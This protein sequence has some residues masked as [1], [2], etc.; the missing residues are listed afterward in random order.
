MHRVMVRTLRGLEAVARTEVVQ[1]LGD[2]PVALEHRSLRF[3]LPRLDRRLLSLGTV[4]DAFLVLGEVDGIGHRRSALEALAALGRTIDGPA[5]VRTLEAVRPVAGAAAASGAISFDATA[6]FIGRR[7]FSRFEI[8]DRVGAAI[9]AATGWTYRPHGLLATSL[10]FRVHVLRAAATLAV[11]LAERPLHRR[12]YRTRS[13]PGALHPPLARALCLLVE[14]TPGCVL[15]D[16]TCG[17]GTIPIEAALLEPDAEVAGF[18]LEPSAIAAARC[19][20]SRAGTAV[21]LGVADATRLPLDD[22]TVDRLVVNPPWDAMVAAAGGL[23][24][25]R[26]ALWTEAARVLAP[27]G[28]LVALLPAGSSPVV[29]GV[30]SEVVASVRVHGAEA[31]VVRARC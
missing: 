16:P 12:A 1:L 10:S 24:R 14:P 18:D 5:I 3:A 13:R 15:V 30:D 22:D 11:R 7:N 4:D 28:S 2:R 6:S 23:R 8:E 31:V 9:A 19:N 26:G 27:R 20:A 21:R 25:R 29:A 17:V